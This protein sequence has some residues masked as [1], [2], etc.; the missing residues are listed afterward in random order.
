MPLP[1]GTPGGA[2]AHLAVQVAA[3]RG[4]IAGLDARMDDLEGQAKALPAPKGPPAVR[5]ADLDEAQASAVR[6]DLAQ[7]VTE[8]LFVIYPSARDAI[9]ECWLAHADAVTEV[10]VTWL[11]YRRVFTPDKPPL[12]DA[13]V[14][15][16]RWLPGMLRRVAAI[17]AK[18]SGV[19]GCIISRGNRP[20]Y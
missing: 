19:A 9:R 10:S 15:H 14:F 2:L 18:C 6:A 7:W 5:W 20:S 11:E 4:Q 16:D 3:H 17:T 12:A 8:V 13:L 1:D